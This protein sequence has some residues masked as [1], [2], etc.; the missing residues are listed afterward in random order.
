MISRQ[1]ENLKTSKSSRTGYLRSFKTSSCI[2]AATIAF[3]SI[4]CAKD[5]VTASPRIK[6]KH[7]PESPKMASSPTFSAIDPNQFDAESPPFSAQQLWD[8]IYSLIIDYN[9]DIKPQDIENALG[10]T[11]NRGNYLDGSGTYYTRIGKPKS[12]Y[13]SLSI[14]YGTQGEAR[15]GIYWKPSSFGRHYLSREMV[16]ESLSHG[17]WKFQGELIHSGTQRDIYQ[18]NRNGLFVDFK[19]DIVVQIVFGQIIE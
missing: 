11:L 18:Y 3:G 6:E 7:A 13:E 8:R 12:W 2:L 4:S 17:E 16:R 15:F 9:G 14:Q 19:G 10:T 1:L 5:H